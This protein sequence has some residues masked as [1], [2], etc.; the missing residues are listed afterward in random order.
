MAARLGHAWLRGVIH[1]GDVM[2]YGAKTLVAFYST[3]D[4]I[5]SYTRL[6]RVDESA[7]LATALGTG[8]ARFEFSKD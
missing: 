3:F 7:G 1:A 2:L 5:Y 6:G 4:S 8:S